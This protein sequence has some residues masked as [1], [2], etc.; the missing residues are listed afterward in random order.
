[1]EGAIMNAIDKCAIFNSINAEGIPT[2]GGVRGVGLD[3]LWQD[4]PLGRGEERVEPNGAF[5]ETVIAAAQQ[6]IEFF[7][8]ASGGR[9]RHPKNEEAVF[10]LINAL[11][12]LNERTA[13]REA[14]QVEG[15]HQA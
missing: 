14:R 1:M 9:F 15:T 11:R 4:G 7:Q 6:R 12:C 5:V 13:E 8:D 3:I 2:G 10:H